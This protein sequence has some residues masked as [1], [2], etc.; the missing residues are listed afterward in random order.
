M[1]ENMIP[2]K[3][4]LNFVPMDATR[5]IITGAFNIH[6]LPTSSIQ[7]LEARGGKMHSVP[8]TNVGA[9]KCVLTATGRRSSSDAS[10]HKRQPAAT[11]QANR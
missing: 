7:Q 1:C 9:N 11:V 10:A 4:V 8:C 2:N 3:T 6:M 5:D